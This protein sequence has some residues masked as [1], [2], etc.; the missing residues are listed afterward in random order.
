[1]ISASIGASTAT[2]PS[3]FLIASI[4]D[5]KIYNFALATAQIQARYTAEL[6][7]Y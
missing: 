2:T 1:M 5:F 3:G 4:N 7:L 6:G